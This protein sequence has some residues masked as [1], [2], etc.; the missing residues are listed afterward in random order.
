[1][2]NINFNSIWKGHNI[3]INAIQINNKCPVQDFLDELAELE[4]KKTDKLFHLLDLQN[5]KFINKQKIRK[6]HFTCDH[7][8]ELKPTGQVRI[9]FVYLKRL[10]N[11]I[12]LLDGF[13]K[14]KRKWPNNKI[15]KT[16]Q[17]CK[18]IRIYEGNLNA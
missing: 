18:I 9:S 17:L 2:K 3:A 8:F 15:K 10:Y 12:C 5:G 11:T 16:E 4:Q 13:K 7:C 1:M 6:L 14:K